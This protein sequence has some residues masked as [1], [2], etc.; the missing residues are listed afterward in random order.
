[1]LTTSVDDMGGMSF[2][3]CRIMDIETSAVVS[4]AMAPAESSPQSIK[5]A[6]TSL[7]QQL[8]AK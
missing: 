8:L 7:A 5:D 1:M 3:T 2:I 4:S 6:C